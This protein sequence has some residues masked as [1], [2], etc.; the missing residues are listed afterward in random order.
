LI[1]IDNAGAL[2]E[3]ESVEKGRSADPSTPA[4]VDAVSASWLPV[5]MLAWQSTA[6]QA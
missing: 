6:I 3:V 1:P 4:S 5:P 2:V